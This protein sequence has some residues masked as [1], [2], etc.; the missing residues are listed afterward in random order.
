MAYT[1][2]KGG[3]TETPPDP[4]RAQSPTPPPPPPRGCRR[5]LRPLFSTAANLSFSPSRLAADDIFLNHSPAAMNATPHAFLGRDRW[6]LGAFLPPPPRRRRPS[7]GAAKCCCSE[8]KLPK[9][10]SVGAG[11]PLRAAGVSA[12]VA[13][14]GGDGDFPGGRVRA[15]PAQSFVSPR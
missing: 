2:K 15:M 7:G 9:L 5:R 10:A 12:A 6:Y 8:T 14:A 1:K 4:A 3:L 13:A 11:G